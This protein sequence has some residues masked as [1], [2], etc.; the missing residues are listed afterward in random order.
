MSKTSVL[1]YIVLTISIGYAFVY[2]SFGDLSVLNEKKQKYED[3]L[4]KIEN[5]ENKK[6]ELL[7]KFEEIPETD[8][9]TVRTILPDSLNFVKLAA[10]IDAVASHYGMSIRDISNKSADSGSSISEAKPQGPYQSSIVAFSFAGS[11]PT[12]LKFMS[13]LEKSL[14]ILDVKSVTIKTGDKGVN[15]YQVEFEVYWVKP[16]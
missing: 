9:E 16:S 10:D 3:A 11:Y 14:R 13:E 8:K 12:F 2:P 15:E 4:S 5:I 7:T 6:G 1:A